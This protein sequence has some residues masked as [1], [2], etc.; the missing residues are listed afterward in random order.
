MTLQRLSTL[1]TFDFTD[2]MD[3]KDW[4]LVHHRRD[5]SRSVIDII[6]NDRT[7]IWLDLG[8]EDDGG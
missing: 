7:W 1:R 3:F 6:R 4:R 5:R 2:F 8:L